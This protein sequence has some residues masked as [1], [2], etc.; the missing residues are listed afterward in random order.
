MNLLKK[1][2][3]SW[4]LRLGLGIMYVYSGYSLTAHPTSWHWTTRSLPQLFQNLIDSIGIDIFLRAQ[5]IIELIIALFLLAWFL[6]KGFLKIAAALA[7]AEMLFI[8]LLVGVDLITFRDL[9]LLG[10]TVALLIIS[11]KHNGRI[12]ST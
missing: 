11:F 5:G 3:P 8:L 12:Q 7:T 10:A 6:P 1:I 9:G 2:R 4:A